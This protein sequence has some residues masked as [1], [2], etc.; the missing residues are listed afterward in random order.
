MIAITPL[1][2]KSLRTLL[3]KSDAHGHDLRMQIRQL[4]EVSGVGSEQNLK[5]PRAVMPITAS[6]ANCEE[7]RNCKSVLHRIRPISRGLVSAGLLIA[8]SG[9]AILFHQ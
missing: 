6:A 1:G 9:R 3:P 5:K 4:R 2:P 8:T 7:N